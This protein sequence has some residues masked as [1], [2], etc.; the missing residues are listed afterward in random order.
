MKINVIW[1]QANKM[2]KNPTIDQ[3]IIWHKSHEENCK[4]RA[5]PDKLKQIILER[6]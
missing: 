5:M 2:P 4:C 6:K 3:R 1:H